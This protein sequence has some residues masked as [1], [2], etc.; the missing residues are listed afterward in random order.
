MGGRFQGYL[1]RSPNKKWD[2]LLIV[3]AGTAADPCAPFT[4]F[5]TPLATALQLSP[6]RSGFLHTRHIGPYSSVG[7][8]AYRCRLLELVRQAFRTSRCKYQVADLL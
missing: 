7:V 5:P 3:I 4:P 1:T 2:I 8:C 6:S